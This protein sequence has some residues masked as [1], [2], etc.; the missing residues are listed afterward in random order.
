[1]IR[2]KEYTAQRDTEF[3]TAMGERVKGAILLDQRWSWKREQPFQAHRSSV[4]IGFNLMRPIHQ[5]FWKKRSGERE[6]RKT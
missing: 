4:H 6:D 2:M 5:I 3:I 1:M